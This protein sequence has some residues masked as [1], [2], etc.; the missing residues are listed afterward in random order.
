MAEVTVEVGGIYGNGCGLDKETEIRKFLQEHVS[1]LGEEL[2]AGFFETSE[3][4]SLADGTRGPGILVLEALEKTPHYSTRESGSG[5]VLNLLSRIVGGG[6]GFGFGYEGCSEAFY[7]DLYK[8]VP[9]LNVSF[10]VTVVGYGDEY[11]S[12]F[13]ELSEKGWK[14]ASVTLYV[15]DEDAQEHRE[16][17]DA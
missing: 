10:D 8:I 17:G 4:V 16:Q 2:S 12:V 13:Y 11:S 1:E 14:V 15:W 7:R 6:A 3:D 9:E 5:V